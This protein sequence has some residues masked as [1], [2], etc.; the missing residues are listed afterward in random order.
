MEDGVK[1]LTWGH[2]VGLPKSF[3]PLPGAKVAPWATVGLTL[4]PPFLGETLTSSP[5]EHFFTFQELM[6]PWLGG[7][8]IFCHF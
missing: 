2:L 3:L 7:S 1:V 8:L 5:W 4:L 6:L